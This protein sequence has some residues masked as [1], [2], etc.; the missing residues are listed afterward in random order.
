M[1]YSRFSLVSSLI[2]SINSV[3]TTIS[4]SK[5]MPHFTVDIHTLALSVCASISAL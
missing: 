5:S 4:V 1:L 3:G 2:R